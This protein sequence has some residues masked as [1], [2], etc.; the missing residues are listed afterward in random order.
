MTYTNIDNKF[1]M[2]NYADDTTFISTIIKVNNQST[3]MINNINQ[4][5][6]NVHNWLLAQRIS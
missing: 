2:I 6:T 4:E 5:L 3:G 1:D